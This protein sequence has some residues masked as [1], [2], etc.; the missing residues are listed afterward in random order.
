METFGSLILPGYQPWNW[1][2]NGTKVKAG[3]HFPHLILEDEG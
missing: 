1:C 3:T 2:E